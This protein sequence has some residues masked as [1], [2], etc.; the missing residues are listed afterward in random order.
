MR[1]HLLFHPRSRDVEASAEPFTDHPDWP[2]RELEIADG[3]WSADGRVDYRA[4]IDW[5][6]RAR[7]DGA[8]MWPQLP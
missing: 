4:A 2:R 3:E 7:P 1:V 8:P 6:D 5:W